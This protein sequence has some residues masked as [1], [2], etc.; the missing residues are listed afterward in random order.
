M[1]QSSLIFSKKNETNIINYTWWLLLQ[2]ANVY[3]VVF[4]GVFSCSS[5]ENTP[6]KFIEN[7]TTKNWK[8]LDKY[9]EIF[10]KHQFYYIKWGLRGTKLHRH[11]LRDVRAFFSVKNLIV[12]FGWS[13]LG[14]GITF[15]RKRKSCLVSYVCTSPY[16][17]FTI[18]KTRLFKYIENFPTK[19]LKVFR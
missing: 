18:S 3:C 12:V 13:F 4:V 2:I 15:L 9:A 5:L 6:V 14:T 8:F 17:L 7:F 19:K 1:S 16:T 10:H 11:V